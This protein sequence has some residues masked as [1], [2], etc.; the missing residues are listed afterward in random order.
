M[1]YFFNIASVMTLR[2]GW[3]LEYEITSIYHQSFKTQFGIFA[4]EYRS[5]VEKENPYFYA[6]AI[7]K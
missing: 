7:F 6:G 3:E 4:E 2:F 1:G 5:N